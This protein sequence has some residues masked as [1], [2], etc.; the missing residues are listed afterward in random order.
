MA[1]GKITAKQQQILDYIKDEILKKF[2]LNKTQYK[3]CIA[4]K[5]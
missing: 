2:K 4:N 1:Y 5:C 3:N